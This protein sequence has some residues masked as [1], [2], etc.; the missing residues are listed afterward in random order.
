MITV[1]YDCRI[2]IYDRCRIC[3]IYILHLS[4]L[5]VKTFLKFL[6]KF[7]AVHNVFGQKRMFFDFFDYPLVKSGIM[8]YNI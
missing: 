7:S 8:V 5:F 6:F 4:Y 1:F 2:R 3:Y